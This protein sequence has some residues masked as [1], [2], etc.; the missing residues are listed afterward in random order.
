MDGLIHRSSRDKGARIDDSTW[1]ERLDVD[2]D[3]EPECEEEEEEEDAPLVIGVLLPHVAGNCLMVF[4]L[5]VLPGI[6][7]SL[8]GSGSSISTY[9]SS[10]CCV[11]QAVPIFA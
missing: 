3:L 8:S 7:V 6:G 9:V 10:F 1:D 2:G 5:G 4:S 11:P